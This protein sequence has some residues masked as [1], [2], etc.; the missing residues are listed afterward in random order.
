MGLQA[1]LRGLAII[2]HVARTLGR[3]AHRSLLMNA[4]ARWTS[5]YAD[6]KLDREYE[7]ELIRKLSLARSHAVGVGG[8]LT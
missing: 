4:I 8:Y 3:E 6:I 5:K 2:T 7:A 1:Y